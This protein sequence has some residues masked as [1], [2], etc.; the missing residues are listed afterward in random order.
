M[1][2]HEDGFEV[3]LNPRPS[4]TVRL[5]V[6]VET[7]ASLEKVAASRDMSLEALLKLYV[8][9]GLRHDLARFTQ[10]AWLRRQPMFWLAICHQKTKW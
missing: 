4:E 1:K 7:V 5:Q 2:K 10:I 6:P 8:G 9:Q 3:R